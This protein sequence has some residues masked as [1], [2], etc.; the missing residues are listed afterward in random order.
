MTRVNNATLTSQV[1]QAIRTDIIEGVLAPG[2]RMRY[3]DLGGR[4]AVSSTPLREALQRLAAEGLVDIDPRS[5]AS[6]T[7][8]SRPD[9]DDTYWVRGMLEVMAVQRSLE[10]GD[11]AWATTVETAYGAFRDATVA[12]QSDDATERLV[13]QT[14][15]HRAFHDSLTEACGSRWL[16]R[17]LKTLNDHAERYRMLNVTEGFGDAL[18]DHAALGAAAVSRH[19]Q[20]VEL[21]W[22]HRS[23]YLDRLAQRLDEA[24]PVTNVA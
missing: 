2:I 16:L 10:R 15:A 17:L 22:S 5:G 3:T 20:L 1:E 9:L 24:E 14:R 21:L 18:D 7:T 12:M 8:V 13:A 23:A 6:V 4:Y 19:P 11:S